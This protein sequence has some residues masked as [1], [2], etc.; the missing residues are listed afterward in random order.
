MMCLAAAL[1]KVDLEDEVFSYN[2]YGDFY[3]TWLYFALYI[4]GAIQEGELA[5]LQLE[6][7]KTRYP[8]IYTL[9]DMEHTFN[10][11]YFEYSGQKAALS[12]FQVYKNLTQAVG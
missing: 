12:Y 10:T 4:T 1:N 3:E 8:N 11:A 5:N 7:F 9:Y 6:F 2:P